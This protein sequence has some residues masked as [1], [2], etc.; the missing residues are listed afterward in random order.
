MT[1]GKTGRG[2]KQRRL[3]AL[4]IL[5][6]GAFPAFAH[7]HSASLCERCARAASSRSQG[8]VERRR[9]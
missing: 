1:T 7:I 4:A 9:V 5:K 3:N 8:D 6:Y 2:G